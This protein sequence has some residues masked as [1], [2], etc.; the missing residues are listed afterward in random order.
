MFSFFFS[1]KLLY[2]DLIP[3]CEF[4]YQLYDSDYEIYISSPDLTKNPLTHIFQI[5][6]WIFQRLLDHSISMIDLLF[7]YPL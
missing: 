5:S 6:T 3:S 1:S 4:K 2:S 7:I